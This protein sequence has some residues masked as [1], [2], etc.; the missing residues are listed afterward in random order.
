MYTTI[1][2][3]GPDMSFLNDEIV[4]AIDSDAETARLRAVNA[5]LETLAYAL[6]HDLR[7]PLRAIEGF[8]QALNDEVATTMNDSALR[9]LHEIHAS[10]ARMQEM[11]NKW[12]SFI[13]S[14]NYCLHRERVSMTELAQS[15]V[16]E[17]RAADSTRVV[18]VIVEPDLSVSSDRVLLRELLQNLI[19][20]SWKFTRNKRDSAIIEVGKCNRNGMITYFVRDNGVGIAPGS[21][22][23]AFEPFTRLHDTGTFDGAGIGLTIVRRIVEAHG[24]TA[25]VES[26]LGKGTTIRFTLPSP[27]RDAGGQAALWCLSTAHNI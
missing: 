21:A 23:L 2:C 15:V 24:G 11:I 6:S 8:A 18:S 22:Q 25:W 26:E 4:S 17:L 12:L 16:T 14:D 1:Q 3:Y 10:V 7:A 20:N 9:S 13:R 19:G 27:S 5:N